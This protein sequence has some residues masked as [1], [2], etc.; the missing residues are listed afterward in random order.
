[1]GCLTQTLPSRRILASFLLFTQLPVGVYKVHSSC[2]LLPVVCRLGIMFFDDAVA[3]VREMLRVLRPGG[4]VA[5]A[6]WHESRH[7]PF[8]SALIDVVSDGR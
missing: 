6:V 7:N 3:S 5:L 8:F 2:L 1:M 4:R